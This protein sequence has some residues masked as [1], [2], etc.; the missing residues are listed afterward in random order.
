MKIGL[1]KARESDCLEYLLRALASMYMVGATVNVENLY[2]AVSYPVP[3]GTPMISPLIKWDFS[4]DWD[5]L[6]MNSYNKIEREF[7]VDAHNTESKVCHLFCII[8]THVV[9]LL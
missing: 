1:L 9:K 2:P 6:R 4:Q 7:T 5:S 3:V 8:A